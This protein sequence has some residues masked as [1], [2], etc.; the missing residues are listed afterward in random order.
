MRSTINKA[1]FIVLTTLLISPV[2]AEEATAPKAR[3]SV[4][5]NPEPINYGATG[6]NNAQKAATTNSKELATSKSSAQTASK[7]ATGAISG[8]TNYNNQEKE[9]IQTA[10]ENLTNAM[11]S[12]DIATI[13]HAKQKLATAKQSADTSSKA[14]T[15]NL[16]A[17]NK[18]LNSTLKSPVPDLVTS[19]QEIINKAI[20]KL[21]NA[22][23]SSNADDIKAAETGLVA[24]KAEATDQ[25]H[26][27]KRKEEQERIAKLSTRNRLAT[28]DFIETFKSS[29]GHAICLNFFG[30]TYLSGKCNPYNLGLFKFFIDTRKQ[31]NNKNKTLVTTNH[32]VYFNNAFDPLNSLVSP[33]SGKVPRDLNQ[34]VSEQIF[35]Q[36]RSQESRTPINQVMNRAEFANYLFSSLISPYYVKPLALNKDQKNNYNIPLTPLHINLRMM[37]RFGFSEYSACINQRSTKK[38]DPIAYTNLSTLCHFL[39]PKNK[40][41]L[42][43]IIQFYSTYKVLKTSINGCMQTGLTVEPKTI[44]DIKKFKGRF[45]V[46]SKPINILLGTKEKYY[47]LGCYTKWKNTPYAFFGLYPL[48]SFANGFYVLN[49]NIVSIFGLL[50]NPKGIN[51][52]LKKIKTNGKEQASLIKTVN[53]L[54]SGISLYKLVNISIPNQ[55]TINPKEANNLLKNIKSNLS[56]LDDNINP[57]ILKWFAQVFE[58]ANHPKMISLEDIFGNSNYNNLSSGGLGKLIHAKKIECKGPVSLT[59]TTLTRSSKPSSKSK[60]TYY[61]QELIYRFIKQLGEIKKMPELYS[62]PLNTSLNRLEI[63]EASLYSKNKYPVMA[64][65]LSFNLDLKT[66]KGPSLSQ[67]NTNITTDKPQILASYKQNQ[68]NFFTQIQQKG[69][70]ADIAGFLSTKT[71]SLAAIHQLTSSR[72]TEYTLKCDGKTIAATPMDILHHNATYRTRNNAWFNQIQHSSDMSF[73]LKEMNFLLAE[74]RAMKTLLKKQH[75]LLLGIT[76]NWLT[77]NQ[78]SMGASFNQHSLKIEDHVKSYGIGRSESEAKMIRRNMQ[79][80]QSGGKS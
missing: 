42:I 4:Q 2:V 55:S 66:S 1:F 10:I 16:K 59:K 34:K 46:S 54:T 22:I 13:D 73:L 37:Q 74:E 53:L 6:S 33:S 57:F 18:L 29:M 61:S 44:K 28:R 76:N 62:A 71:A 15:A 30:G 56:D 52:T 5:K 80:Q 68:K 77:T 69:Y 35:T 14:R 51:T 25:K 78:S 70:Q 8:P 21:Q 72:D 19:E 64:A 36:G 39:K 24:A 41:H 67:A 65:G 26:A 23:M 63:F 45:Y 20:E 47:A 17:A 48:N 7:E 12:N 75:E 79:D 9:K 40:Q 27:R 49:K 43:N 38:D 32:S 3:D 11:D 60:S 31:E 58:E 50:S